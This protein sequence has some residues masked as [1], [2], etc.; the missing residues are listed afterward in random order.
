MCFG[1][2]PK[3][4]NYY[5]LY[6]DDYSLTPGY[7][8]AEFVKLVYDFEI[9]DTLEANQSYETAL[10]SFGRHLGDV[11]FTNYKN[12]AISSD[13]AILSKLSLFFDENPYYS[14]RL[15]D[16]YLSEYV[17]ENSSHFNGEYIQRDGT[18]CVF[19][20]MVGKRKNV[21][22]IQGDIF[23]HNQDQIYRI[24]ISVEDGR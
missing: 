9:P 11:T 23:G 2:S 12:K 20:K 5:V 1:C 14:Y 18:A 10:Y 16:Y 6:F 22:I 15:D 13:K 17:S 3:R 7:D 19:G 24:T 21:V 4:E 8:N